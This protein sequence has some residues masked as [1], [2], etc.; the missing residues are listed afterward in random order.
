LC[1]SASQGLCTVFLVTV[2][3]ASTLTA[4][5][6]LRL[7]DALSDVLDRIVTIARDALDGAD[8]V[9]ITLV[10]DDRPWTAA[11]TGQ[12]ALDADE[13]QY[14]RGYGPCIDAGVSGTLLRVDDMRGE[15]RWPDYAAVV[16]PRGVLSSLSVPLPLQ[17]ELVGA[18]N[19]YA[20]VSGAFNSSTDAAVE[21]ASH[22]AVALSNAISYVDATEL[23]HNMRAAM[24]SRSVIEQAK[25]IIM[26]QNRCDAGQAF[27]V[28]RRASQG[29]NVKL[30]DL[31]HDLVAGVAESAPGGS[32]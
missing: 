28:L 22:V 18:M 24:E 1:C 12:L 3:P 10:R 15:T 14:D 9:S 13:M 11:Y 25:G 8:E 16:A 20:R 19:C 23:A 29:R 26:A 30:R 32:R 21:L 4:L 2:L 7:G 31:A 6:S 27:E 5:L 17:T